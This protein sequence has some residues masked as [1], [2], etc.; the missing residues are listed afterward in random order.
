M[1]KAEF[2][3]LK[4]P[5]YQGGLLLGVLVLLAVWILAIREIGGQNLSQINISVNSV[6]GVRNLI[7]EKEIYD[8]LKREL[9]RDIGLIP[10][11]DLDLRLM[12]KA[13]SED[14]RVHE[15]E[16]YVDAQNSLSID[17]RQRRPIMRV[18]SENGQQF[19]IDQEGNF[20]ARSEFKAVRVPV[21]TGHIEAYDDNWKWRPDSRLY[22]AYEIAKRL[23]NDEFLG[24]LIEQVHF[25]RGKRIVLIP[26]VGKEKIVLDY[27]DDLDEKL[28]KIKPLYR[29][30]AS[31]DGWNKYRE[32]DISY[33]KQVI[34]RNPVKP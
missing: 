6:E 7:E 11:K 15:V 32:I 25:E 20:V 30:L 5:M 3:R 27:V 18:M 21:V 23:H 33:N 22:M 29:H 31:T 14:T 34:G 2:K 24:S 26:K 8:I 17:I 13:L 4:G 16:V 10:I 12:E 1:I 28:S 9:K 19:Y